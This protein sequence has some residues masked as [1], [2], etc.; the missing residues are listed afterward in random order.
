[1]RSLLE[2]ISSAAM[3]EHYATPEPAE[4]IKLQVHISSF[5]YK[6]NGLPKDK[7]GHGGGYIFDCRGVK[8]PGRYKD[9]KFLSGNDESVKQF[10]DRET[11]M[12]E[13]MQ[14][15]EGLV[16]L[17]V[18]DYMSRGFDHLSVA[19]G[20]TGGQHRSVYAAEHLA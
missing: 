2:N 14:H 15:V 10:L 13:F 19:F 8:N 18:E 16:A 9:Y 7:T 5:S 12:P 1:L 4:D 20:C 6:K 11:R 3:Q 17:N